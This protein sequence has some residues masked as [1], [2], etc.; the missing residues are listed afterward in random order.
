MH[1]GHRNRTVTINIFTLS[2]VVIPP[3]HCVLLFLVA[4]SV[5]NPGQVPVVTDVDF[6]HSFLIWFC[7]KFQIILHN[8][9]HVFHFSC[10]IRA[11]LLHKLKLLTNHINVQKIFPS[12]ICWQYPSRTISEEIFHNLLPFKLTNSL[13]FAEFD[14]NPVSCS[15]LLKF[16]LNL[17][18]IKC[19]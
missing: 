11:R 4:L 7:N 10:S 15:C 13:T 6:Y 17:L 16:V 3:H 8:P 2:S 19:C 12:F 14:R 18:T 5:A 1:V 9:C